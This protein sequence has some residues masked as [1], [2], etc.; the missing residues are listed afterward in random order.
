[1]CV[2]KQEVNKWRF[3]LCTYIYIYIYI[4]CH[5]HTDCFVLSQ[6]W[7]DTRDTSRWNRNLADFT[8]VGYLTAEPSTASA[9]EFYAYV[10][11]FICLH[12]RLTATGVLNS[13]EEV[14][15]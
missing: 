1:M 13:L 4:Y 12:M 7:L 14:N 9:K 6:L 5:L 8:P 10:L 15:L 11:F 2:F 3:E